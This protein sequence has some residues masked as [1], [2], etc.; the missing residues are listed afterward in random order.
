MTAGGFRPVT[1]PEK[2][3]CDQKLERD[4]AFAHIGSFLD[5]IELAYNDILVGKYIP[6]KIGRLLAS[7]QTQQESRWQSKVGL[8]L[9]YGPTAKED[10]FKYEVGDWV[11]YRA[12]D[13]YEI[14]VVNE[15]APKP[16]TPSLILSPAHIIGKLSNPDLLW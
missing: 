11:F 7:E 5:G 13:G 9:K 10:G 16:W 3:L 15:N 1:M 4:K 14:G 6:E 2:I 12:S 8:V